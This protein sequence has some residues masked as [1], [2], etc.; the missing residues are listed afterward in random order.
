MD[1]KYCKEKHEIID[2]R[3]DDHGN[4]IR[5]LETSDAVNTDRIEKLTNSIDSQ[6]KAIW[7]LVIT[8]FGTFIGFFIWYIQS[9]PRV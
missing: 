4:R 1:E 7:G 6:T 3:L 5:R 2:R 8:L 9:L